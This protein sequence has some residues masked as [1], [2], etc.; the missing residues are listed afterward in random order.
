M[1]LWLHDGSRAG[2]PPRCACVGCARATDQAESLAR[3]LRRRSARIARPARVRMRRRKPC[4]LARRRLFGWKVRLLTVLSLTVQS[5]ACT[6][7]GMAVLGRSTTTARPRH[8]SDRG[9]AADVVLGRLGNGT[10][11]PQRG[12]T[13]LLTRHG[14]PGP[15]DTPYGRRLLGKSACMASAT[16]LASPRYRLFH[17]PAAT[18]KFAFTP[19]GKHCAHSTEHLPSVGTCREASNE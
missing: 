16:L 8:T 7:S 5:L 19:C 15:D 14:P 17:N 12:Q 4:F 3:P 9:H 11:A 13:D 2:S 10:G 6:E 1:H 18:L